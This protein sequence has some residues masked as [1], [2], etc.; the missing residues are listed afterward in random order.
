MLKY[1]DRPW[2]MSALER[3]D[4]IERQ[5]WLRIVEGVSGI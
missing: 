2:E 3:G 4:W 1:G 5:I